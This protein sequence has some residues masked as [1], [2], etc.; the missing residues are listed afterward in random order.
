MIIIVLTLL[1][2]CPIGGLVYCCAAGAT[3]YGRKADDDAQMEFIK[4]YRES[5]K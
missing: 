3:P 5:R 4:K 2:A 1:I